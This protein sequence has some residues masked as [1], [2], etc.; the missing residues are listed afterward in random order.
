[1]TGVRAAFEEQARACEE[2]GSPFHGRLLALCAA[3]LT[4]GGAVAA[5]VLN[6]RG[7]PSHRADSVALRLAGALHALKLS[8]RSELVA[9]YPPSNVDDAALWHAVESTMADEADV[10]LAWLESPPQTNEVRRSAAVIPALHLVAQ[11]FGRPIE[12]FELG[13]SGGLNLRADRYR[14]D[15]PG[16]R[17]GPA[18]A[19]TILTP[20]WSGP[21]PPDAAPHIVRR[22]GGD[23]NP[24]DPASDADRL[25]L[26]AYLWPDQAHRLKLTEAA[27]ATAAEHPAEITR[28]DAGAWLA[29][30][31]DRSAEGHCRFV[32][33]T[34]A[35]QYFP[36][37]TKAACAAALDAA[38]ATASRDS[39]IVRFGMEADGGRGAALTLTTWPGEEIVSLGRADFHGRWI[40]WTG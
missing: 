14:L 30:V 2:L 3:H 31:L 1:M 7:D 8:G 39:P 21:Y 28:G 9:V 38:G 36:E 22:A 37:A 13:T 5:R 17:F 26:L 4:P 27:I 25:R 40:E 23:L 19:R 32:F 29:D 16:A 20:D 34:I 35:W 10:I 6:W 12:M 24:L 11:R 15:L 33:H 18:D